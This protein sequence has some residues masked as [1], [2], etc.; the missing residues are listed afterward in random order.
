MC[1]V[2]CRTALF[3]GLLT[4]LVISTHPLGHA[5]AVDF[6]WASDLGFAKGPSMKAAR[7]GHWQA[8]L[9]DGRVAAFGG[10]GKGFVA[11][12][13]VDVWSPSTKT[14]ST[15]TMQYTHDGSA[16]AKLQDGR[17]LL[18]G[19]SA[20]LGVPAY[21][22]SEIYNPTT[23]TF[24]LTGNMVR[25]RAGAASATLTNGK[26]LIAGA[27]W[28]HNDAHTYGELYDPITGAFKATGP[29]KVP[30]ANAVAIPT[31]DGKAVV[32]GGMGPQAVP[33]YIEKVEQYNP[34]TNKFK[35]YKNTLIGGQTGWYI[36]QQMCMRA[37]D[38]QKMTDGRYLLIAHRTETGVLEFMLVTFDPAK[39]VFA[40]L[41]T[42]PEL[43]EL[44]GGGFPWAPLLD[45]R[46]NKAYLLGTS[47]VEGKTQ[48]MSLYAVDLGTMTLTEETGQLVPSYYVAS[49]AQSVVEDGRILV[50]GGTK[51]GSNFN[52]VANTFFAQPS[53]ARE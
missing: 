22:T 44:A 49:C 31:K 27:W 7:M 23:K 17:Y 28:I 39:K 41:H 35:I 12:K 52:P 51:D 24:T 10:H 1:T 18:A 19:G 32:A 4:C 53:S 2:D 50:T 20:N 42:N 25:F 37:I 26:V 5:Q 29:L 8:T 34:A 21:A 40:A 13:T 6:S 36:N 30:R 16:F 47:A 9:P 43:P 48:K 11:L 15:A 14:F 45:N 33:A 3:S 46:E 38:D